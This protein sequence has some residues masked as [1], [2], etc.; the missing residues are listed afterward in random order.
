MLKVLEMP[1]AL[2]VITHEDYEI[3]LEL[4][5][6]VKSVAAV[7]EKLD[8]PKSRANRLIQHG[9]PQLNLPPIREAVEKKV[10]VQT[11]LFNELGSEKDKKFYLFAYMTIRQKMY[12]SLKGISG[13]PSVSIKEIETVDSLYDLREKIR[14][15]EKDLA[16]YLL[17]PYDDMTAKDIRDLALGKRKPK[18]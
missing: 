16:S 13:A 17:L 10:E 15:E 18:K 14:D 5:G 1:K 12:D 3:A 8:I 2:K 9:L 11:Q 7:A 6:R 4:Y